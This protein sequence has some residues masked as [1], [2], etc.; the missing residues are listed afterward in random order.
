VILLLFE[1]ARLRVVAG[2]LPAGA[3]LAMAFG[4]RLRAYRD[5][6]VTTLRVNPIASDLRECIAAL[7]LL[8]DLV[9]AAST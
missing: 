3:R 9:N 4:T 7:G 5:C 2:W 8:V 1:Q 6:G